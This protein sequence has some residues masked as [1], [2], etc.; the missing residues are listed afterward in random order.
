LDK[1]NE[2]QDLTEASLWD[3]LLPSDDIIKKCGKRF[4]LKPIERIAMRCAT[5]AVLKHVGGVP[6]A[7]DLL[8]DMRDDLIDQGLDPNG[9]KHD[10]PNLTDPALVPKRGSE[11]KDPGFAVQKAEAEAIGERMADHFG[12]DLFKLLQEVPKRFLKNRAYRS[13]NNI[14]TYARRVVADARLVMQIKPIRAAASTSVANKEARANER[15]LPPAPSLVPG[16]SSGGGAKEAKSSPVLRLERSLSAQSSTSDSRDVSTVNGQTISTEDDFVLNN[17]C[18]WLLDM[19]RKVSR[20]E[21]LREA[22]KRRE[23]N[24]HK[25]VIACRQM[26]QLVQSIQGAAS[27]GE[28]GQVPPRQQRQHLPQHPSYT[29]AVLQLFLFEPQQRLRRPGGVGQG[30]M[31]GEGAGA[32]V[33]G[34]HGGH[35][36]HGGQGSDT[37]PVNMWDHCSRN[38]LDDI[39]QSHLQFLQSVALWLH[40]H[41]GQLSLLPSDTTDTSAATAAAAIVG[42]QHGSDGGGG[43]ATGGGGG[44]NAAGAADVSV[45]ASSA[46][47]SV[48]S[49]SPASPPK[50]PEQLMLVLLRWCGVVLESLAQTRHAREKNALVKRGQVPGPLGSP[51]LGPQSPPSAGA[52]GTTMSNGGLAMG[53]EG[54]EGEG[55]DEKII[56][57]LLGAL[58]GRLKRAAAAAAK[59]SSGDGRAGDANTK[60]AERK[61]AKTA[62][63][64]KAAVHGLTFPMPL[65][66]F[67]SSTTCNSSHPARD[68]MR[69]GRDTYWQSNVTQSTDAKT[70]SFRPAADEVEGPSGER[71]ASRMVRALRAKRQE[72]GEKNKC[73][74]LA[75]GRV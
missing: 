4:P 26:S 28:E 53:D 43:D 18:D 11:S 21:A 64:L 50:P 60:A 31:N 24:A 34:G 33:Q 42:G 25:R 2:L 37:T 57:D 5:V 56:H 75:Y 6:A 67:D 19:R 52:M 51:A 47:S 49:S 36:G 20:D 74:E 54:S 7:T 8:R 3:H 1:A 58:R 65:C 62:A 13:R 29:T 35:G 73:G 55:E 71:D 44:G 23:M 70:I 46:S 30:S 45:S 68:A 66:G 15:A 16:R 27:G 59:Q 22:L 40:T 38:L 72:R 48:P 12:I 32:G 41:S 61:A 39:R 10:R 14:E 9:V 63:L 17:I 69:A